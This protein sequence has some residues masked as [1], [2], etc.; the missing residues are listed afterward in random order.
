MLNWI[1]ENIMLADKNVRI[2]N[3]IEIKKID[4]YILKTDKLSQK[5]LRYKQ[6]NK[7]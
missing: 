5:N 2:K 7:R 4:K 3:I 6:N 1:S